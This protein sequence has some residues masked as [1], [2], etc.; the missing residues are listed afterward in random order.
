MSSLVFS[1]VCVLRG[2]SFYLSRVW[3]CAH[4]YSLVIFICNLVH[5]PKHRHLV[6]MYGT[7]EKWVFLLHFSF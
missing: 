2:L 6:I 4:V 7:H 5:S 1:S 3:L